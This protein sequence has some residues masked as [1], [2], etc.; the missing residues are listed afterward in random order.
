MTEF[1]R[2]ADVICLPSHGKEGIPRT[3]IEAAAAGKPIVTTDNTG[4][5]DA[6]I[7]GETGYLVPVKD[8]SVLS[9]KLEHLIKNPK[10]RQQMGKRGRE[11]AEQTFAM[12]IIAKQTEEIYCADKK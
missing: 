12:D 11:F 9:E 5:R 2:K 4:C 7:D 10:L 8:E 1:Y 6:V 3:L